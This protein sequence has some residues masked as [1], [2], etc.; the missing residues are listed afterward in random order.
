MNLSKL[1]QRTLHVLAQGGRIVHYRNKQGH[2]SA[3][4]CYTREGYMLVD[5]SLPIFAKLKKKR[6]IISENG[7]PYRI[8]MAGIQAVRPQL[9]NR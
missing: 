7:Q 9:D 5:C 6:L 1:E 4:E 2:I 3:I 8:S